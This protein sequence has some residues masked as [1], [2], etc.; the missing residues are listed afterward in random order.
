[1][2]GILPAT[3]LFKVEIGSVFSKWDYSVELNKHM[4]LSK[5]KHLFWKLHHL[6]HSFPLRVDLAFKEMLSATFTLS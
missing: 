5:G 6:A 4:Y 3:L 1:L 2:K